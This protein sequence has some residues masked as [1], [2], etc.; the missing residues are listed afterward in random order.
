MGSFGSGRKEIRF[1]VNEKGCQLNVSHCRDK[2]GYPK[3]YRNG[4]YYRMSHWTYELRYGKSFP[5]GKFACHHCDEPACQ[6]WENGHLYVGTALENAQEMVRHGRWR[7]NAPKGE[8][9]FRSKLTDENV[10]EIRTALGTLKEIGKKF[11]ISGVQVLRI[12]QHKYW[13]HV[14]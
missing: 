12:K 13:K 14:A 4:K 11:G 1:V 8:N 9:H 3:I 5:D 2:N 6:S 10:F 7:G